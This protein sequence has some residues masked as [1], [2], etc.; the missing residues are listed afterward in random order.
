MVILHS[1]V[2]L[3]EGNVIG[4]DPSPAFPKWRPLR[5]SLLR[6]QTASTDG[7]FCQGPGRC[8]EPRGRAERLDSQKTG[9]SMIL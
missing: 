2:S 4:F 7:L 1:Y 8:G 6:S 3:P 5:Y 9:D